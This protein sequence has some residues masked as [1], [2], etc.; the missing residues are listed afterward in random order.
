MAPHGGTDAQQNPFT[1]DSGGGDNGGADN[2]LI[3]SL[4]LIGSE[5]DILR[6]DTTSSTAGSD[7]SGGD[8][9]EKRARLYRRLCEACAIANAILRS[10][11]DDGGT[12][13]KDT[14]SRGGART[15]HLPWSCGG[16][17]PIFGV[18]CDVSADDY[19]HQSGGV[20]GDDAWQS[21]C[22]SSARSPDTNAELGDML[23]KK[24]R[25]SPAADQYFRQPHLRAVCR[26]GNDVNDM[27]HCVGLALR[28]SSELSSRNLPCALECWDAA[29]GHI[30]LI[31]AAE[32][33]PAWVDDDVLQGGV[34]GPG[35]CRN[36]C[37]I[38]NGEVHLIPPSRDTSPSYKS[39]DASKLESVDR[40]SRKDALCI[41]AES[42]A[43]DADMRATAAPEAVQ[44][45]I[46]DR[47]DRT[48]Y[49]HPRRRG[50]ESNLQRA[51]SDEEAS[52][53]PHWHVAAV[54]LPASV[55]RFVQKHP[56]LVPLLVDSFCEHAPSYLKERS[57][58]RNK[59]VDE[60]AQN[61]TPPNGSS[62][63]QS[64][65]K[66][67][68]GTS[69]GNAFP[70]EQM[71]V[72]PIT[73][74]RTNYAELVT[75]RGVVPPFPTPGAYRSVELNRFQR[76]L[77]Q[78]AFGNEDFGDEGKSRK[79]NPFIRAVDVGVRLCAGL[80]WSVSAESKKAA[81]GAAT[82]VD[83]AAVQA[84]GE[85]ERRLRVYWTRID[86]EASREV[87]D[88]SST[89]E[90]NELPWIEEVWQAGPSENTGFDKSLVQALESMS[91]CRVH[92]PELSKPLS[93]EPCPVTRPGMSL[94]EIAKSGMKRALKWQQKEYDDDFFP[95][96]KSWEVDDDGWMNV[97]SL[98]ELEE[99]MRNLSSRKASESENRKPRRTTRR[100]RRKAAAHTTSEANEEKPSEPR[101]EKPPDAQSLDKMIGGLKSFV[102]GEGELEGAVTKNDLDVGKLA[103]TKV[104]PESL[105]SQP[106]NINPRRF[107]NV[108][109]SML[110]NEQ[111]PTSCGPSNDEDDLSK[112]FFHEDVDC[113]SDD[114][115][116]DGSGDEQLMDEQ[117]MP[118]EDPFSLQNIMEAMDDE[119]RT[120]AAP[121]SS[122]KGMSV[123]SEEH[124]G[125]R[126]ADG[127]DLAML[128]NLLKSIDA[129]GGG[130]GPAT[131]ILSEM[132]IFPPRSPDEGENEIEAE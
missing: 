119:L 32:H 38:A 33:L 55:A 87:S 52:S 23:R 85:V 97:D 43:E 83:D 82:E 9:V 13:A 11:S 41:L 27:W 117:L 91:K 68:S 90:Q 16:D 95:L 77:R 4:Y 106:V 30:L 48:D 58:Q 8:G 112:F 45:A 64:D 21:Q 62:N 114:S 44:H 69:L 81:E 93:M 40:M 74:T 59:N 124:A 86:V 19:F 14:T 60:T 132:G 37:W 78:S 109:H 53:N 26:Y 49:S 50:D 122:I 5:E 102:E 67:K 72:T 70:Y 115:E 103:K 63:A 61:G 2:A 24:R 107:L 39:H 12:T 28:L 46:R 3:L 20:D 104:D 57:S 89:T 94:R 79:R 113:I 130:S 88:D 98:E 15:R 99:E 17:G 129:Q 108:L 22:P 34:G 10:S 96:P 47:I 54:A 31:E 29:D 118:G 128:S 127:S 126:G 6:G 100:S 121:H 125:E 84:L 101:E 110:K 56:S 25:K 80:D 123:A 36:R 51:S 35:G 131:T 76:Q 116:S 73:F 71:V 120:D 65:T 42:R 105:M 66:T 92:D 18:H 75:G 7:T 111:T 1:L